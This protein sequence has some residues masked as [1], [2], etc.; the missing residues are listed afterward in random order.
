M[1]S[2]SASTPSESEKQFTDAATGQIINSWHSSNPLKWTLYCG[3]AVEALRL[4]QANS[5]DCIVTSPPYFWLR[6]YEVDGQIG[7]E[8]TIAEYI[9]AVT[10]VMDEAFRVL[11]PSG[12]L[13][14]NLGDT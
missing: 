11:K 3:Q 7:Q 5:V 13:F 8:D 6:D 12:T 10:T 4:I 9:A 14:L 2:H 1:S